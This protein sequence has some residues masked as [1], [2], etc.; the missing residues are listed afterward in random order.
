MSRVITCLIAKLFSIDQ[1]WHKAKSMFMGMMGGRGVG[2]GLDSERV[3][4]NE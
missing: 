2:G 4:E 3:G 1:E